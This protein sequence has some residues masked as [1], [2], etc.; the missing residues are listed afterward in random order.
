MDDEYFKMAK[1][2]LNRI[3]SLDNRLAVLEKGARPMNINSLLNIPQVST[4]L[5]VSIDTV[6]NMIERGELPMVKIGGQWR[7][8]REYLFDWYNKKHKINAQ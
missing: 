8:A 6:R 3:D 7:I 2:L 4:Y 5:A 1:E